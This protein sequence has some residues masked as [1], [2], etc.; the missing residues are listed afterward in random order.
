MISSPLTPKA[1]SGFEFSFQLMGHFRLLQNMVPDRE[2]EGRKG[3]KMEQRMLVRKLQHLS[4]AVLPYLLI[5]SD[6]FI[7]I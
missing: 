5:Q 7:N 1:N 2:Y 4:D 3:C 6:N